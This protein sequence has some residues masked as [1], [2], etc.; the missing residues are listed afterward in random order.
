MVFRNAEAPTP[1]P[2]PDQV[3][4]TGDAT[5]RIDGTHHSRLPFTEADNVTFN[6]GA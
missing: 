3:T 6:C 2:E 5:V 4:F 1:E